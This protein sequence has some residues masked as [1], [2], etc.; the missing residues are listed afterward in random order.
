MIRSIAHPTDFSP[1][2]VAAFEHALA[3]AVIRRC[4]LDILHVGDAGEGGGWGD[5]PQVRQL[6][7]RWGMLEPGASTEAVH[8][9]TGVTV[10]KVGI[11]DHDPV[12]GMARYLNEH[13]A[14]LIGPQYRDFRLVKLRW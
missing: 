11:H 1:R 9:A 2:G 14:D 7:Q 4:A 6:L 3:L 8:A 12:H 10:R 13:P 5:F